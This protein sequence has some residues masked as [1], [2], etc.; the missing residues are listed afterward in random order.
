[1]PAIVTFLHRFQDIIRIVCL[2]IIVA[3]DNAFFGPFRR[4]VHLLVRTLRRVDQ[5]GSVAL[6]RLD[7][8][9]VSLHIFLVG[10]PGGE[11]ASGLK[12][13]KDEWFQHYG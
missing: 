8:C 2:E 7:A 13:P 12:E 3:L 6:M 9:I 1:M 10:S 11:G 5:V 4:S